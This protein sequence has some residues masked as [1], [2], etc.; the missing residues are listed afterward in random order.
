[1]KSESNTETPSS[2][3]PSDETPSSPTPITS[4]P[5]STTYIYRVDSA[6]DKIY[7]GSM[8]PATGALSEHPAVELDPGTRP[9]AMVLSADKKFLFVAN[10]G[11]NT[12]ETFE[13]DSATGEL[14]SVASRGPREVTILG[15]IYADPLNRFLWS[16]EADASSFYWL[17]A[18]EIQ[19]DG[20]LTYGSTSLLY[21]ATDY[22]RNF[23]ADPTG[24][25]L[26]VNFDHASIMVTEISNTG[27][28]HPIDGNK[29]YGSPPPNAMAFNSATSRLY[30]APGINGDMI[31]S[32]L[33]DSTSGDLTFETYLDGEQGPSF[34]DIAVNTA[35][36][37]M[38]LL[39]EVPAALK[40]FVIDT[41]GVKAVLSFTNSV[42]FPAG[43]APK[44]MA[45]LLDDGYL[46]TACSNSSGQ[47]FS[48]KVEADGSLTLKD[49]A[50]RTGMTVN[51]MVA[52]SF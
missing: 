23:I 13:I 32:F 28:V 6:A 12:I 44:I 43:C 24:S 17:I 30:G 15:K 22:A 11:S 40:S 33:V 5:T 27:K 25:F 41:S 20:S 7:F 1:M 48:L 45:P 21:G 47:T 9:T 19:P 10:T 16:Y 42:S 51:S 36:D 26:Y 35:G 2:P 50:T 18:Y 3:P 8:D 37:R 31:Y 49:T 29:T 52:V 39:S 38:Y 4:T 46:L 14:T 34:E